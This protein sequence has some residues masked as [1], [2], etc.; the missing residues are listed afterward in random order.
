MNKIHFERK[1]ECSYIGQLLSVVVV[2]IN[3]VR[4]IVCA[5]FCVLKNI[6]KN[7]DVDVFF[8]KNRQNIA[9]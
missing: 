7:I 2:A 4:C 6:V 8:Q 9:L 5:M 1:V 3:I